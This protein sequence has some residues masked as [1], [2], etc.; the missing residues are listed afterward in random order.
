MSVVGI[1]TLGDP[2][3]ALAADHSYADYYK[4]PDYLELVG[5]YV[6]DP[7]VTG[8]GFHSYVAGD[9]FKSKYFRP[10]MT[11][12]EDAGLYMAVMEPP[13][14]PVIKV[15]TVAAQNNDGLQY[16]L[17]TP[18]NGVSVFIP[19]RVNPEVK[20]YLAGMFDNLQKSTDFAAVL[21]D[22]TF[23]RSFADTQINRCY[24]V[25]SPL[26]EYTI[27]PFEKQTKTKDLATTAALI[28]NNKTGQLQIATINPDADTLY[29]PMSWFKA[30]KLLRKEI[31]WGKQYPLS[32]W[33]YSGQGN[34]LYP[35]WNAAIASYTQ[36]GPVLIVRTGEYAI[37]AGRNS[38][39]LT[40]KSP[41][42]DVI[43][44]KAYRLR[45]E[46]GKMVLLKVS[47]TKKYSFSQDNR[48]NCTTAAAKKYGDMI[49]V[50]LTGNKDAACRLSIRDH[51]NDSLVTYVY[52]R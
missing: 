35:G 2:F 37:P 6:N 52:V 39:E 15:K 31:G 44:R 28:I 20:K 43:Y 50:V 4:V 32:Y 9:T 30:Y 14:K 26:A 13:D 25:G 8:L 45:N 3:P 23:N 36:Q 1:K 7:A 34:P 38:V 49:L 18:Q 42:V 24:K 5:M 33:L 16:V 40:A 19:G 10:I 27:I 48:Q 51:D 12:L 11:G 21:S 46:T 29:Q 47:E 17:G 41:K 22:K